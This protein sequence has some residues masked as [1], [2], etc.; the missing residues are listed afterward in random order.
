VPTH[1]PAGSATTPFRLVDETSSV[2]PVCGKPIAPGEGTKVLA[3]GREYTV[4]DPACG[5]ELAKNPDTYLDP[6]GTPKNGRKDSKP[7]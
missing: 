2:C 1:G 4:D 7:M 3:R 5:Q 6:D